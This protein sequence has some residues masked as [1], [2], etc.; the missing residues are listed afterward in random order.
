AASPK[1]TE[2]RSIGT[3]LFTITD[4]PAVTNS[5]FGDSSELCGAGAAAGGACDGLANPKPS[6][7]NRKKQAPITASTDLACCFKTAAP[8]S[9]Q[10][11]LCYWCCSSECGCWA[12]GNFSSVCF[13]PLKTCTR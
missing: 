5:S 13:A 12:S 3:A 11:L 7:R 1:P 9:P 8:W 4:L 10:A 2:T 6:T